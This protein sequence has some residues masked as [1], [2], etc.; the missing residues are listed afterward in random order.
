MHRHAIRHILAAAGL[1]IGCWSTLPAF[2]SSGDA[3]QDFAAEVQGK[4]EMAA[5][6]QIELPHAVVDPFGSESFGMALVTGKPKG[7]N[8]Y[9][10]YSVSTTR[11]RRRSSSARSLRPSGWGYCR[12]NRRLPLVSCALSMPSDEAK[13]EAQFLIAAD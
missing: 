5:R 11:R 9:V 13:A 6:A 8:G 2:A 10:S 3:W 7:A 1:G 12:T 4:C